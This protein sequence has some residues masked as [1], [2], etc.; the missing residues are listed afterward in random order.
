[1]STRLS[2]PSH[3]QPRGSFLGQAVDMIL[4]RRAQW[5]HRHTQMELAWGISWV[6]SLASLRDGPNKWYQKTFNGTAG[7]YG[8][9]ATT[10]SSSQWRGCYNCGR[11]EAFSEAAVDIA[12]VSIHRHSCSGGNFSAAGLHICMN[13]QVPW[14]SRSGEVATIVAVSD[15]FRRLLSIFRFPAS[16]ITAASGGNFSA[17]GLLICRHHQAP[18]EE[19]PVAR[20]PQCVAVTRHFGGCL[21]ISRYQLPPSWLQAEA[22]AVADLQSSLSI[23]NGAHIG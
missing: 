17:A 11:G 2:E 18:I 14:R 22:I 4:G 1:M 8:G 13:H 15:H 9:L 3:L 7:A 6:A 5:H 20:L 16:T 12:I 10:S 23:P 19:L 21:S